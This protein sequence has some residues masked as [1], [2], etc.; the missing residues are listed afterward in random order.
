MVCSS[1]V[2]LVRLAIHIQLW[3]S[4]SVS[5]RR[6]R[7]LRR[8]HRAHTDDHQTKCW[9]RRLPW[10]G[11]WAINYSCKVRNYCL[12]QHL[13]M[14]GR[15][16]CRKRWLIVWWI[17]FFFFSSISNW[18]YIWLSICLKQWYN[19]LI[20]FNVR[21]AFPFLRVGHIWLDWLMKPDRFARRIS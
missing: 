1:M 7:R 19:W 20:T 18:W 16:T 17:I 4:R 3:W 2:Q 5:G 21:D 9:C 15:D 10:F 13:D 14:M 8:R 6:R 11:Q 12:R